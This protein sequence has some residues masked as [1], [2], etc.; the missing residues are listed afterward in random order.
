[1]EYVAGLELR[2][3]DAA[4]YHRGGTSFHYNIGTLYDEIKLRYQN[5]GPLYV[6]VSHVVLPTF[7][8]SVS[9]SMY[10]GPITSTLNS[11]DIKLYSFSYAS[12]DEL[13]KLVVYSSK[14]CLVS[15][16]CKK[17]AEDHSNHVCTDFDEDTALQLTYEN[18]RFELRNAKNYMC[19]ITGNLAQILHF[20]NEIL[21]SYTSAER[22]SAISDETLIK[23]CTKP[24]KIDSGLIYSN[25]C[26]FLSCDKRYMNII[27][28]DI[29]N[30]SMATAHGKF[31]V[32]ATVNVETGKIVC[33]KGIGGIKRL[34]LRGSKEFNFSVVDCDYTDYSFENI[35]LKKNP[36]IIHVDILTTL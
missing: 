2:T 6:N 35:D 34:D 36:L 13:C 25:P 10:Y 14:C 27:C 23:N 5:V 15:K 21:Q 29:V 33:G 28:R 19:V 12:Y 18:G 22:E 9:F 3:S 24:I 16:N 26:Q 32:L 11:T 8:R 4:C 17:N 31:R 30:A 20:E 7:R 1:M